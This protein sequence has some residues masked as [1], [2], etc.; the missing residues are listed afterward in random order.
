VGEL[1]QLYGRQADELAATVEAALAE[2]QTYY[3]QAAEVLAGLHRRR[4]ARLNLLVRALGEQHGGLDEAAHLAA[5]GSTIETAAPAT[6]FGYG[7]GDRVRDPRSGCTG[8]V[9][10]HALTPTQ[11]DQGYPVAEV[12]WDGWE[13][14]VDLE[15]AVAHGL[16]HLH[17]PDARTTHDGHD[18]QVPR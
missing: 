14:A 8:R 12:V 11:R 2:E 10:I 5:T 1:V 18:G 13:V 16:E 17:T 7:N 15:L 4:T 3:E 9:R 6:V